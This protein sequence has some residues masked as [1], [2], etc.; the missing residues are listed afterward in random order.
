MSYCS[1]RFSCAISTESRKP[2]VTTSAVRAPLRSISAL[3]ASVVPWMTRPISPGAAPARPS[4]VPMPSSTPRSG[5]SCVVSTLVETCAAPLS[6]TT[7]VKVPPTSTPICH[8]IRDSAIRPRACREFLRPAG[9]YCRRTV[10]AGPGAVILRTGRAPR[11]PSRMKIVAGRKIYIRTLRGVVFFHSVD[12]IFGLLSRR[13]R[14]AFRL[15]TFPVYASPR[16][17]ARRRRFA[18]GGRH[19]GRHGF[20]YR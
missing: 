10:A 19:L 1:K 15:D 20:A 3:V 16:N 2:S 5:A 13:T 18:S 6:S 9:R 12:T 4:A 8:R 11:A 17:Q 14:D 7:S